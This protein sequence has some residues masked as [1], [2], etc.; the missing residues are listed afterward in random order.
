MSYAIAQSTSLLNS[1]FD[2]VASFMDA[3]V[4]KMVLSTKRAQIV[5]L[6]QAMNRMDDRQ[7]ADIGITRSEIADYADMAIRVHG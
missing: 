4:E 2:A 5:Q 7:L 6:K 3:F 1:I